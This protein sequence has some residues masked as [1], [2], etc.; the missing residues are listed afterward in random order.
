MSADLAEGGVG[1][2]GGGE[3][4]RVEVEVEKRDATGESSGGARDWGVNVVMHT[5]EVEEAD[6]TRQEV[7]KNYE[8]K[9]GRERLGKVMSKHLK[10]GQPS[11]LDSGKVPSYKDVVCAILHRQL[12]IRLE[13]N[14]KQNPPSSKIVDELSGELEEIAK[15]RTSDCQEQVTNDWRAQEEQLDQMVEQ[16]VI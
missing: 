5:F 7:Y 10:F 1:E 15:I 9:I 8:N 11:P 2:Q 4:L 12:I 3:D 13:Q 14:L 16:R 6:K